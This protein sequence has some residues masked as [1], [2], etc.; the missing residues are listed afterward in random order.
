MKTQYDLA[1]IGG[2]IM[3]LM[4]AYYASRYTKNIIVIEKSSIGNVRSGSYGLTRS[5]RSDYIDPLYARLARR[6]RINWQQFE[7]SNGIKIFNSCGVLN[8]C[9]TSITPDIYKTY[10]YQS[11]VALKRLKFKNKTFIRTDLKRSFPQFD[12]DYGSLDRDAGVLLLPKVERSLLTVL[13]K[14]AVT[15]REQSILQSI[16]L[17]QN[18]YE[19]VIE[20]C[21]IRAK[22]IV[23]TAGVWVNDVLKLF[24]LPNLSLPVTAVTPPQTAYFIPNSTDYNEFTADRFPVFAYLDV[25]IFGHPIIP[26]VTP[27]VKIGF[28]K[29]PNF[30]STSTGITNAE[31]FIRRC[32]PKLMSAKRYTPNKKEL[33]SFEMTPDGDF[34]IGQ[35]PQ[36]SRVY[37]AAGFCGTGYKFAPVIAETLI[38]MVG[39]RKPQY[40][41][42]RFDP[43]R[44]ISSNDILK[45]E[46]L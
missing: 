17:R 24:G 38:N 35:L 5:I 22:S 43:S 11:T 20:N 40:D 36:L 4:S 12:A 25:G 41:M 6:S 34:I 27:G 1:I 8:I 10:A 23:I 26:G 46:Y 14:R 16:T 37:V 3:G 18:T 9:K 42:K 13:K 31:D 21:K 33:G 32:I 28:F 15:L 39:G 45:K 44:F 2:G 30:D 19:L 7:K 29:P